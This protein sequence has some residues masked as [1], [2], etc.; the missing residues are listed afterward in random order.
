MSS[1]TK[2][3]LPCWLKRCIVYN[4]ISKDFN[5]PS[6]VNE[7]ILRYISS[8]D[9]KNIQKMITQL[10][11]EIDRFEKGEYIINE[12]DKSVWFDDPFYD[13]SIGRG[14]KLDLSYAPQPERPLSRPLRTLPEGY[15]PRA[16]CESFL[17]CGQG[18]C[19]YVYENQ[20]IYNMLVENELGEQILNSG[21]N[22]YNMNMINIIYY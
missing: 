18:R 11:N 22:I 13:I 12:K 17:P 19:R 1:L 14:S 5:M 2:R 4:I 21:K 16:F 3:K 8:I 10:N 6:V 20:K 9:Q 7:K 15:F